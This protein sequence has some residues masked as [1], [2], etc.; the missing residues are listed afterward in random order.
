V[1]APAPSAAPVASAASAVLAALALALGGCERG[2]AREWL[3]ERG[4][5][6]PG[7][8]IP[9][10]MPVNATDCPDGIARCEEGTVSASRLATIPMPCRGPAADCMC[11]WDPV[12]ECATGC[13]ADG[14]EVVVER[15]A[16]TTQL[17]SA[18]RDARPYAVPSMPVPPAASNDPPCDEGDRYRCAG[19][20]IVECASG[21]AVG[22]CLRGC[23]TDGSSIDDDAVNREAA[24]AIL[25]SR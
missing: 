14:V 3:A 11:P 21:R 15:G 20:R 2:C 10:P 18:P 9:G 5:G 17:C 12:G 6:P 22:Q 25:C 4:L 19:G 7:G 16:A 23:F 24:F 13:V 8:G 1:K